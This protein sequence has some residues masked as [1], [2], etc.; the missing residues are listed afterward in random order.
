MRKT[1]SLQLIIIG[2][3]LT[4]AIT[5][6]GQDAP[7]NSFALLRIE[8]PQYEQAVQRVTGQWPSSD[9]KIRVVILKQ[10]APYDLRDQ[11]YSLGTLLTL[12][13]SNDGTPRDAFEVIE[14]DGVTRRYPKLVEFRG[15]IM[16]D[17]CGMFGRFNSGD[18]ARIALLPGRYTIS[19]HVVD[20]RG[21][22]IPG[23]LPTKRLNLS[24]GQYDITAE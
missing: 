16:F 18:I 19:F 8:I 10:E 7:V 5:T 22:V 9:Q 20:S 24:P 2:A 17:S 21:V 13:Y 15:D 6:F 14:S 23:I 4:L 1:L 12:L 11:A 3:L